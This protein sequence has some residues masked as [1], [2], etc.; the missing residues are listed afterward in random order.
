MKQFNIRVYGILINKQNQLL[1][2]HEERNGYKMTKLPGGGLEWG[3]GTKETLV[4]EFK[5]ELGINIR[6][7]KLFYVCDFFQISAFNSNDQLISFYYEVEA[8]LRELP[9][10]GDFNREKIRFEWKPINDLQQNDFTFPI[11][12]EVI[13]MILLK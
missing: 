13:K 8:D 7:G 3:E 10:N 11:D 2:C 6:V 1:V 9:I 4:R 5:E 12:R